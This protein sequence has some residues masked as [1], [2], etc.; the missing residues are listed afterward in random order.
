MGAAQVI[1]KALSG[2]G[3]TDKRLLK[4]DSLDALFEKFRASGRRILAPR[5]QG[6][7]IVFD[8]VTTPAELPGEYTQTTAS[9]KSAVLP[10][11]EELLRYRFEGKDVQVTDGEAPPTPT[12]LFGV[13]PCDASGFETLDALYSWDYQDKFFKNR[14]ENTVVIGISCTKSD[15]YCFCTSV[16]GGPGATRGSD[17]LLTPLPGG[18]YLAEILTDRGRE[19]VAM[20]PELFGAAPDADKEK[21]LA[22]VPARFDLK[23]LGGKLP[24]LFAKDEIWSEQSL[25]CLG[26]GAC[27][28]LC[29]VCVCFDIQDEA[30]GKG[31][32][33]LRC[34]DSCGLSLFTLHTSGHN[35]RSTQGQRWRQRVMHK[36]SYFPDRLGHLACVGCGRCSRACPADMNL[37][38]HLV[39]LAEAE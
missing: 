37:L 24:A 19:I 3:M 17:I 25:R 10:R 2:N 36:F 26:C 32:A 29:P 34:W 5:E 30:N 15:A 4:R 13:R 11:C 7:S 35:P 31:G 1:R 12:V 14:L 6:Q 27:A 18:D 22:Q 33:R 20:A 39:E 9:P 21:Q 16:G 38:E 8:E 28:F 23:A